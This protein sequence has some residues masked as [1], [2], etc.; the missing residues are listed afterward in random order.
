VNLTNSCTHEAGRAIIVIDAVDSWCGS[1][2][3]GES[4]SMRLAKTEFLVQMEGV[5]KEEGMKASHRM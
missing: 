4:D 3:E 1:C 2:S 5:G